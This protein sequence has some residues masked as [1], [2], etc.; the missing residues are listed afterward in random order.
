MDEALENS[1]IVQLTWDL[2]S[3]ISLRLREK[4]SN[5]DIPTSKYNKVKHRVAMKAIQREVIPLKN[6]WG[7]NIGESARDLW[8]G[9][10]DDDFRVN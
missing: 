6:C 9:S 2:S 3:Y 7:D 5:E 8:G 1:D 10:L 4:L